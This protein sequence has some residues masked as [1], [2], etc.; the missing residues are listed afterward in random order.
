MVLQA[1][2]DIIVRVDGHA[3][4][5]SDY[6]RRCVSTLLSSDALNVGGYVTAAGR[7]L[8][9]R[10]VAMALGSFWGNGGARYRCSPPC[11][12][13]LRRYRSVRR[14]AS[15]DPGR[16]LGPFVEWEVNED[17][18]FNARILDA[19]GRI[20]LHPSIRAVYFPRTSLRA[21]ARQYFRY[22]RLKC[23]VVALHPRRLRFRQVAPPL[24]VIA[25]L[26]GFAVSSVGMLPVP[27]LLS[28]PLAYLGAIGLASA[29]LAFRSGQ[30][31]FACVLPAVLATLHVSYG[32][33]A[34]LG[35][36]QMVASLLRPRSHRGTWNA[37][38]SAILVGTQRPQ[39][40]MPP[41]RSPC[42]GPT[43]RRSRTRPPT[44][45]ERQSAGTIGLSTENKA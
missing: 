42:S 45:S 38:F 19:N 40:A 1:Q 21:L 7:G 30:P 11:A 18:E 24:L 32:T 44:R 26:S 15:R 12:T 16:R 39:L 3:E 29:R 4:V 43:T 28:A 17:C 22:G 34:L 14:L 10:T 6:V 31:A 27:F 25:F 9:G 41:A 37:R 13:R 33:G 20:L 5:A 2:G 36:G 8:V 35:A 23:R